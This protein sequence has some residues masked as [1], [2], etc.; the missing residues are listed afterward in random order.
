MCWNERRMEHG[1]GERA[2]ARAIVLARVTSRRG[3]GAQIRRDQYRCLRGRPC[4]QLSAQGAC[5]AHRRQRSLHRHVHDAEEKQERD[6]APRRPFPTTP[7]PANSHLS[8]V[9][10]C[11]KI[12][13]ESGPKTS[14]EFV[15]RPTKRG[16]GSAGGSTGGSATAWPL[17]AYPLILESRFPTTDHAPQAPQHH[18]RASEH[19]QLL[20]HNRELHKPSLMSRLR[21][22][23]S[24]SI[25]SNSVAWYVPR[26]CP[27]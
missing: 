13:I 20:Q 14:S 21:S 4:A 10:A 6:P 19:G 9:V 15:V 5:V 3:V 26:T 27:C 25:A 1:A 16:L 8:N 22:A 2:V 23:R 17:N 24:V 12:I 7:S 18:D 11:P